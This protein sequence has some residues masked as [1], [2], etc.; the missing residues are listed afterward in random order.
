MFIEVE[1]RLRECSCPM[2]GR[3]QL[4][5]QAGRVDESSGSL[6]SWAGLPRMIT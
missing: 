1:L 3:P 5:A 2:S 6:G 4:L